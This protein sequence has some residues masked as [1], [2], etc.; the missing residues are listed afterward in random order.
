MITN[1]L[2]FLI[3]ILFGF[4]KKWNIPVKLVEAFGFPVLLLL[5]QGS[6]RKISS[7]FV[8]TSNKGRFCQR[9]QN[10][11]IHTNRN[12]MQRKN[13]IQRLTCSRQSKFKRGLSTLDDW[14]KCRACATEWAICWML[15]R[16]GIHFIYI[17]NINNRLYHM[18]KT[19]G[20]FQSASRW[21]TEIAIVQLWWRIGYIYSCSLI[22]VLDFAHLV[23]LSLIFNVFWNRA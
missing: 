16:F 2:Q 3:Y 4:L 6:T 7:L 12:R 19:I 1:D 22:N 17:Y 18:V 20:L 5:R 13:T 14:R 10:Q 11:L 9:E 21:K 23:C 8:N 15:P